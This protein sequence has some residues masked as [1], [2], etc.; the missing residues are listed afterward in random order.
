V[1]LHPL[2]LVA[3]LCARVPP[4]RFH[5]R[6]Y[7]GVLA[8]NANARDEV[9]PGREP[10]AQEQLPLFTPA[11]GG[12]LEPPPRVRHPWAWLL[13]RVFAADIV[14]CPRCDGR[15]RLLDVVTDADHIARLLARVG[16]SARA[17]PSPDPTGQLELHFGD[18]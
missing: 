5:M 16:P 11:D 9:V 3:R 1:L 10:V 14:R 6:R 17:P 13:R 4:P 7:H 12:P 2:D 18:A 8:G 15:M